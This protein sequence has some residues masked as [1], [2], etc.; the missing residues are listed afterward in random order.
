V[1]GPPSCCR[2]SRQLA[3]LTQRSEL[4]REAHEASMKERVRASVP[5]GV[6][7]VSLGVTI[8]SPSLLRRCCC[9]RSQELV[10]QLANARLEQQLQISAAEKQKVGVVP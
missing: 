4:E 5:L 10:I 2:L 3:A 9:A 1:T 6:T 8:A 7:I